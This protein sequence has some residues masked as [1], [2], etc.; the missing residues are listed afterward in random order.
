MQRGQVDKAVLAAYW[1]ENKWLTTVTLI[2]WAAVSFGAVLF[3]KSLNAVVVFGFPLGY[4]LAA[5]GSLIVFV[6]LVFNYAR[7]MNRI[8]RKHDLHEEEA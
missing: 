7:A 4:Y 8:D 3:A 1:S 6:L 2:V 5:Q